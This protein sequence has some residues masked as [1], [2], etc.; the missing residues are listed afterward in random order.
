MGKVIYTYKSTSDDDTE[1]IE[2]GVPNDII[3]WHKGCP[4]V[5]VPND[6][7]LLL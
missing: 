1:S 3:A 4:F 6:Q 5:K 7:V 2:F